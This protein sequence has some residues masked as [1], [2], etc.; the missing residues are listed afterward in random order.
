MCFLIDNL[1]FCPKVC[2]I[3]V[4]ELLRVQVHLQRLVIS[5]C[6]DWRAAFRVWSSGCVVF[7]SEGCVLGFEWIKYPATI[8]CPKSC[9]KIG[10]NS[11][12]NYRE[13]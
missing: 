12:R 10:Q 5:G 11:I 6:R 1:G 3:W 7:Q 8:Y 13:L 2:I 4:L 9:T